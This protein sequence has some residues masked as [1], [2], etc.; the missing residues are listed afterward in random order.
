M[1]TTKDLFVLAEAGI[2]QRT[3]EHY[4][5]RMTI[6]IEAELRRC[7]SVAEYIRF[8]EWLPAISAEIM[9]VKVVLAAA[10]GGL[11]IN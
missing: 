11:S 10:S 7:R 2:L 5:V 4:I 8:H 3:G 1:A 6:T 9:K